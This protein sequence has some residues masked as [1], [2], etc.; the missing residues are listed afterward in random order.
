VTSDGN[1]R[2]FERW[3][4]LGALALAGVGFAAFL[5]RR[6]ALTDGSPGIDAERPSDLVRLRIG[7]PRSQDAS[8]PVA[9][10]DA[11][12][13]QPPDVVNPDPTP[14]RDVRSPDDAPPAPRTVIV[15]SGETLGEIVQREL[16]SVSRLAEVVRLNGLDDPDSIRA[17]VEIRLPAE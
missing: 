9:P 2:S 11:N 16:G 14:G 4:L 7:G 15:R 12:R 5:S 8:Q 1:D 17:G 13:P 10:D 6:G 3:A